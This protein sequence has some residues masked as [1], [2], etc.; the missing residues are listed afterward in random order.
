[1]KI[2]WGYLPLEALGVLLAQ[3]ALGFSMV[4]AAMT[5]ITAAAV[6]VLLVAL[7]A[8]YHPHWPRTSTGRRD[9]ARDQI[10]ALSWAFMTRDETVSARGLQTVREAATT[11]LA[12]HGVDL[13]DPA[14]E[15]AARALLGDASYDLFQDTQPAT[16]TRVGRC[17]DRLA[18]I[19]ATSQPAH[20]QP[21][22][23]TQPP[24]QP[25]TT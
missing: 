15:G 20:S 21:S 10:S 12:L 6:T 25:R 13:T 14:Q 8:V 19:T 7:P 22:Q 9:G 24:S 17:I 5:I 23:P 1:M 11:R 18:E 4:H 3:Q 2:L 16:M